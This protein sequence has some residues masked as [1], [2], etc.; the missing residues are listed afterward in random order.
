VTQAVTFTS[1]AGGK[2]APGL[3]GTDAPDGESKDIKVIDAAPADGG[4]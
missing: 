1:G 4:S 2:G 3:V